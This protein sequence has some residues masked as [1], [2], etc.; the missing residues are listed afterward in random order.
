MCVCVCVCVNVCA[1][2]CMSVLSL[3]STASGDYI[4]LS[5]VRDTFRIDLRHYNAL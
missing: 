1:C 2:V 3:L 4:L 5:V